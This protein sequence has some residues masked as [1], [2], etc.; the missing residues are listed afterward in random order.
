ME[1]QTK[2]LLGLAAAGVVAYLV[3]KGKKTSSSIL[4]GFM[5]FCKD[6]F[7]VWTDGKHYTGKECDG[8]GGDSGKPN[9][10]PNVVNSNTKFDDKLYRKYND[11]L[12]C[13][14][15]P[16]DEICVNN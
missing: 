13:L 5:V 12:Y 16:S 8:H 4:S 3:L 1:K 7:H 14:D 15:Y 10:S 6:G 11:P 9:P 2:I